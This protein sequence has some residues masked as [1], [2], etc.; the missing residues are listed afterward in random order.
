MTLGGG[1][2]MHQGQKINC[3][4]LKLVNTTEGIRLR[5]KYAHMREDN[6]NA[7]ENNAHIPRLT[8]LYP[9]GTS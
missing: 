1:W 7:R 3:I 2:I 4:A 9:F 6:T 5:L 8:I